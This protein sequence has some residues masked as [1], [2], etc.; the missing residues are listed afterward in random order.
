MRIFGGDRIDC[1]GLLDR[2]GLFVWKVTMRLY[3]EARIVQ[4]WL[5]QSLMQSIRG[6]RRN[7]IKKAFKLVSYMLLK[8]NS[9]GVQF[10]QYTIKLLPSK[11]IRVLYSDSSV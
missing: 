6:G 1:W 11:L 4:C 2:M 7:K 9:I 8:Q 10:D 3:L 5:E